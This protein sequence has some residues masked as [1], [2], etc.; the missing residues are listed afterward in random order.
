MVDM[1][2][3]CESV[4]FFIYLATHEAT[5]PSGNTDLIVFVELLNDFG[6]EMLAC[7]WNYLELF[8]F[9]V[10][11]IQWLEKR[12]VLW[13]ISTYKLQLGNTSGETPTRETLILLSVWNNCDFG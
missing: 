3:V 1:V 5:H 6:C 4:V 11:L 10:D 13:L 12:W 8:C 2:Y 7:T 9:C